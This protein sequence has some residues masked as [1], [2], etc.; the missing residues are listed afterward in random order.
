MCCRLLIWISYYLSLQN[1][2]EWRGNHHTHFHPHH[3]TQSR[4]PAF[5]SYSLFTFRKASAV[6][7]L[8][9][10]HL[11]TVNKHLSANVSR[12]VDI[13]HVDNRWTTLTLWQNISCGVWQ[14]NNCSLS[15]WI[16]EEWDLW[17]GKPPRGERQ[18][19]ATPTET[20]KDQ[21]AK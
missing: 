11:S 17:A 14:K 19:N 7:L 15:V 5:S 2:A 4:T 18:R 9:L 10:S 6:L 21:N 1:L 20:S 12:L 16:K 13:S 3:S 8:R